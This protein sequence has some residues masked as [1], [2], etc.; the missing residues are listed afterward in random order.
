MKDSIGGNAKTLMIVNISP[1][2]YNKEESKMSLYYGSQAKRIQNEPQ[3]N[4]E[5]EQ[6]RSLKEEFKTLRKE[7]E[8]LREEKQ[9]ALKSTGDTYKSFSQF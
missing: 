9:K 4:T 2:E 5:N 8:K 6:M 7:N 3:Q 1:S